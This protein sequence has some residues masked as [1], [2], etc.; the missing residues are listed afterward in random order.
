MFQ[1]LIADGG[2]DTEIRSWDI[3][4]GPGH[5]AM[6]PDYFWDHH[7][8]GK[9]FEDPAKDIPGQPDTFEWVVEGNG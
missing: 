3:G 7:Q 1:S 8:E 6:W 4:I 9:F 2:H 5:G